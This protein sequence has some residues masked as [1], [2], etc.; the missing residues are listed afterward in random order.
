MRARALTFAPPVSERGRMAA[1]IRVYGKLATVTVADTNPIWTWR[2]ADAD[3]QTTLQNDLVNDDWKFY[4]AGSGAVPNPELALA[5]RMAE[6]HGGEV[7]SFD[8]VD[9]SDRS[10]VY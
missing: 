4:D 8:P 3:L 2:C 10:V 7:V 1:T 9:R 5:R 6:A